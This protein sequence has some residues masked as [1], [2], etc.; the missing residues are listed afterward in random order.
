MDVQYALPWVIKIHG[1]YWQGQLTVALLSLQRF[2]Y[3]R[4][5]K[6][7]HDSNILKSQYRW[8]DK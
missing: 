1:M 2:K 8:T 6:G 3:A 4:K 7:I 5:E